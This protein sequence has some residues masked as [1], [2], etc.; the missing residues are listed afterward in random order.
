MQSQRPK[1]V[2][3]RFNLRRKPLLVDKEPDLLLQDELEA[4]DVQF[5]SLSASEKLGGFFDDGFETGCAR[6]ARAEVLVFG[7]DVEFAL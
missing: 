4:L 7:F 5:E 3:Q 1:I 6:T 2:H